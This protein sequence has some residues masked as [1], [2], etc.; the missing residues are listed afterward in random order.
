MQQCA[1]PGVCFLTFVALAV[2]LAGTPGWAGW[3]AAGAGV[4]AAAMAPLSPWALM[5]GALAA[6]RGV[7][8][9][10]MA[11]SEGAPRLVEP[12][13]M[14]TL[15]ALATVPSA[16]QGPANVPALAMAAAAA[17]GLLPV[18]VGVGRPWRTGAPAR[19]VWALL[20]RPAQGADLVFAW[21]G[22]LL[23]L[24]AGHSH[25]GLGM[26]C[27]LQTRALVS[28]H[29]PRPLEEAVLAGD[30]AFLRYAAETPL[31]LPDARSLR[32][33]WRDEWA[34]DWGAEAPTRQPPQPSSRGQPNEA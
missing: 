9:A 22:G 16:A 20:R 30:P 18:A 33:A 29:T 27:L 2:A 8:E 17:L 4:A 10:R 7:L 3:A 5:M 19:G 26:W 21:A 14:A 25:W 24:G 15:A 32:A 34:S 12:V 28:A 31:L 13:A 23:L 11:T 6:G 1:G